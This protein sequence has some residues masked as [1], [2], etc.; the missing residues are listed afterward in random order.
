MKEGGRTLEISYPWKCKL[1]EGR[2]RCSKVLPFL[3]LA[4]S[5]PPRQM[6]RDDARDASGA[7]ADAH[8]GG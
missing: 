5:R 6:R 1:T 4:Q 3:T 8:G 7:R 2:E